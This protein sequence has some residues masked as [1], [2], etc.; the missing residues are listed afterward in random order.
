M[1]LIQI[2]PWYQIFNLWCSL[3]GNG[4]S[5]PFDKLLVRI[6]KT[7]VVSHTIHP[8]F[9]PNF[10]RPLWHGHPFTAFMLC[11]LLFGTNYSKLLMTRPI[12]HHI[13]RSTYDGGICNY[14]TWWCPKT[15]TTLCSCMHPISNQTRSEVQTPIDSPLLVGLLLTR[16]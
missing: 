14:Q 7:I 8:M 16:L 5:D 11:H 15:F 13:P 3:L 12:R 6:T 2:S 10:P 4:G 9:L 1:Y